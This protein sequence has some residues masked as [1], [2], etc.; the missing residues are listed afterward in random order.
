MSDHVL[1]G[2]YHEIGKD[3]AAYPAALRELPDAPARLYAVGSLEALRPGLAVIGARK[4]TPYG[5]GCARRFARLAA[6]KGVVIVSGGA[7][8]CDSAAH[9]AA[10]EAGAPTVVFLGGGCD[11]LYP[12]E[13]EALFQEIVDADGAIVSEH[14]WGFAPRPYAF[15]ARNRLI[16]GL[17][18]AVLIVEAGLPSGTFSTADEALSQ[19]KEV[20]V[21]PGAI[22]SEASRGSNR[23]LYQGAV[24]VVDDESFED[25]LFSAMGV[26]KRPQA[27][28][29]ASAGT[30]AG[31]GALVEA[32]AAAP[33]TTDQV[34]QLAVQHFGEADAR[35][36]MMAELAQAEMEGAIS[37]YPDGR[38][39]P[40][41]QE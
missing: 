31:P 5:L 39:G 23:L 37:R 7:R 9:R 35:R 10:L 2:E 13:H 14:P 28:S 26:L 38:W 12:P 32:I 16:A 4:A 24:P 25:V 20:L 1:K 3:N 19:G 33:L 21:V 34:Y 18:E 8:G 27:G 22:T 6:E 30:A 29:G 17:A 15:R 11:C 40:V 41:V 36:A